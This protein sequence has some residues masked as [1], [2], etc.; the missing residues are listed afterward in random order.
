MRAVVVANVAFWVL[1]VVAGMLVWS[2]LDT[3]QWPW[4]TYPNPLHY[5]GRDFMPDGSPTKAQIITA[6]GS[7]FHVVG[8]VP[9]WLNPGQVW[10]DRP[11]AACGHKPFEFWISV[12]GGRYEAFTLEGGY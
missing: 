9:G 10:A 1:L 2:R 4:S 11:G 7:H 8:S 5:C 3:H 12:G 6:D